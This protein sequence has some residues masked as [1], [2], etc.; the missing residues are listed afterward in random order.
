M[1]TPKNTISAY[2]PKRSVLLTMTIATLNVPTVSKASTTT[3]PSESPR[4]PAAMIQTSATSIGAPTATIAFHLS[5]HP[6]SPAAFRSS[7]FSVTVSSAS[8]ILL[9]SRSLIS[10]C[11]CA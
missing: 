9:S 4:R 7:A 5:R 8:G 2:Q 11:S 6:T 3:A 10:C 1:P